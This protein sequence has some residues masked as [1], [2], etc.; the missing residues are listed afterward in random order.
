MTDA[1]I[2]K[3]ALKILVDEALDVIS[4]NQSVLG[5]DELLPMKSAVRVAQK[6]LASIIPVS[7][8]DFDVETYEYDCWGAC[9]P[10]G[11]PG[12]DTDQAIG[13]TFKDV[14]FYVQGAEGGDF[15]TPDKARNRAAN[16]AI[17]ALQEAVDRAVTQ[18]MEE[19][20]VPLPRGDTV[21]FPDGTTISKAENERRIEALSRTVERL[22]K[23]VLYHDTDEVREV[24]RIWLRGD[25]DEHPGEGIMIDWLNPPPGVDEIL[26]RLS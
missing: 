13:F 12:H 1:R 17:A 5:E 18:E 21:I 20:P 23:I 15:P 24:F 4:C 9:T 2:S 26:D 25:A 6:A 14:Q 11:C 10:D 8:S 22:Q 3:R 16:E 7:P 19:K